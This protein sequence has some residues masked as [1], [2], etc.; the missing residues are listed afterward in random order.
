MPLDNTK[1]DQPRQ[2]TRGLRQ[3]DIRKTSDRPHVEVGSCLRQHRE[4]PAL[5]TGNDCLDGPNEIHACTTSDT[6][7]KSNKCFFHA[8]AALESLVSA[9]ADA[10]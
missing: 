3:T 10:H 9:S 7:H 1:L 2:H 8:R 6:R 5:N 4:N